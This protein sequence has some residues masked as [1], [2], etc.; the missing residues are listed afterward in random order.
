[1]ARRDEALQAFEAE[2]VHAWRMMAR[3]PDRERGWLRA[4]TR[5][6]WPDV[7]RDRFTDYADTEARPRTVL[8]R[9]ELA[10]VDALFLGEDCLCSRVVP[11]ERRALLGVVLSL[12][13]W[14]ER[15]GFRW[16]AV[17]VACGGR[18]CGVTSDTLASRYETQLRRLFTAME[19]R[20]ARLAAA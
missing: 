13:A 5:S 15:R 4:G 1:M 18:A 14:P 9:R 17:W 16:D 10:L 19:A 7:V 2:L 6:V 12:K 20:R 11:V 8:S 3:L